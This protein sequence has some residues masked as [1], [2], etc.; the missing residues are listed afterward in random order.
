MAVISHLK[1]SYPD[2]VLTAL[3]C[4]SDK[5]LTKIIGLAETIDESLKVAVVEY[6]RSLKGDS[7]GKPQ[8]K[9]VKSLEDKIEAQ[10]KLVQEQK[11]HSLGGI[12]E[13]L[14]GNVEKL[15]R[16]DF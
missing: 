15:N 5:T 11:V 4:Q 3:L 1:S 6:I 9:R 10:I 8:G 7:R 14:L 12:G 2:E 13:L 16:K